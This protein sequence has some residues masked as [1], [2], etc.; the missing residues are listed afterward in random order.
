[1]PRPGRNFYPRS[2]CAAASATAADE[3]FSGARSFPKTGFHFSGSCSSR[4]R[5]RHF[6]V[7]QTFVVGVDGEKIYADVQHR[8]T[9]IV[10]PGGDGVLVALDGLDQQDRVQIA[11][12]M[13]GAGQGI[14]FH[15][16]DIDLYQVDAGQIERIETDRRHLDHFAF[17]VID[18]L[19]D[20]LGAVALLELETAETCGGG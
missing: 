18:G 20:E 10:Q 4:R 11:D 19:A 16:L 15:S 1:M 9:E 6:D 17:G 14:H 13:A 12:A 8:V 7:G 3:D 2:A 5:V